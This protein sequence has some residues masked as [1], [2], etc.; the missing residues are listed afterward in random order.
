MTNIV[1]ILWARRNN[2]QIFIT[3]QDIESIV[4]YDIVLK[5]A[6]KQI[7]GHTYSP[8][9]CFLYD[10]KQ[11]VS[12]AK[13][14]VIMWKKIRIKETAERIWK[15]QFTFPYSCKPV[16][17]CN[18]VLSGLIQNDRLILFT[19]QLI[20]QLSDDY[21][22]LQED[23]EMMESVRIDPNQ[24]VEEM[25]KVV[26]GPLN[27][28]FPKILKML[29][30][31]QVSEKNLIKY[32]DSVKS[33]VVHPL[34]INMVHYFAARNNGPC[35]QRCF[36]LKMKYLRDLHDKTPLTYASEAKANESIE[37]IVNYL[38]RNRRAQENMTGRELCRL[39]KDS[40]ANLRYFF[41]NAFHIVDGSH[42]PRYGL[43]K[44]QP[45]PRSMRS[46]EGEKIPMKF[47]FTNI[48]TLSTE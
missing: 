34:N 4:L 3:S 16:N 28:L 6:V 27:L 19:P 48:D 38:T 46:L 12:F 8:S 9:Q 22:D 24:N 43:I 40:P 10:K 35:V 17:T 7:D 33:N 15:Q 47:Y 31:E 14:E 20:V 44:G 41:D 13:N 39:I 30:S 11:V 25:E 36:D 37:V 32:V 5:M 18:S 23:L 21:G 26:K 29:Q 1:S 42:I 2:S 45:R